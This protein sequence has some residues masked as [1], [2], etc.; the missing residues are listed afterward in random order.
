MKTK[1]FFGS[2]RVFKF[3]LCFHFRKK[4]RRE[5]EE[6]RR[7]WSS[8]SVLEWSGGLGLWFLPEWA[9][10]RTRIPDEPGWWRRRTGPGSWRPG[11]TWGEQQRETGWIWNEGQSGRL[12][13]QNS[14]DVWTNVQLLL[15]K[16]RRWDVG[17]V[18]PSNQERSGNCCSY[19]PW[20]Q[21]LP[22]KMSCS[23]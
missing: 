13:K 23:C 21:S 18:S 10:S 5:A 17:R 9:G 2:E 6:Q 7:F 11:W 12:N 19:C 1:K 22:S 3:K 20:N 4:E 16:D 15:V 14:S 8:G